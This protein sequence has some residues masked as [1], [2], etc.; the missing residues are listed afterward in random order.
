MRELS[1]EQR[2]EREW[3]PGVNAG[4]AS[5]ARAA[6]LR[7]V[8]AALGIAGL[9]LLVAAS[10]GVTTRAQTVESGLTALPMTSSAV[11][12]A[13]EKKQTTDKEA[14]DAFARPEASS[15]NGPTR[16][17]ALQAAIAKEQAAQRD[18]LLAK[19]A[20]EVSRAAEAAS[21]DARQKELTVADRASRAEGARIAAENLRRAI[22]ARVAAANRRQAVESAADDHG[23][24]R[25]RQIPSVGKAVLLAT[26]AVPVAVAGEAVQVAL[27]LCREPLLA[28]PLVSSA[29]GRAITLALTSGPGTAHRFAPL[30]QASCSTPAIPVT[31]PA[32]MSPSNMGMG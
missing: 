19:T 13:P 20:D 32:T 5:Q 22:A 21:G 28:P 31:G 30:G 11:V 14:L 25:P 4:D 2:T 24:L 10:I 16:S 9:G 29:A 18:E 6:W 12:V 1:G 15:T 27:R 17:P 3:D 23:G 7:Y 8:F 26:A